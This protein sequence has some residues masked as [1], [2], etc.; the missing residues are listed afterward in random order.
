M[1]FPEHYA[2]TLSR[3]SRGFLHSGAPVSTQTSSAVDIE[4]LDEALYW[5]S[6]TPNRGQAWLSFVDQLL[7]TR[8]HITQGGGTHVSQP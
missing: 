1:I 8:T 7:D 3:Y 4:D 6:I 2:R 5:A